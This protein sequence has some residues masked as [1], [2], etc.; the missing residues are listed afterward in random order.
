MMRQT[1]GDEELDLLVSVDE[2]DFLN[3]QKILV[4]N[5]EDGTSGNAFATG[6]S[7]RGPMGEP[8]IEQA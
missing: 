1:A 5:L 3:G 2:K 6:I 8:R 4:R 7:I